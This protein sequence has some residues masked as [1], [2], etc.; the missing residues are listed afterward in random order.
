MNEDFYE[1]AIIEYLVENHDYTHLYGPDVHR[2]TANYQD[3]YLTEILWD[4]LSRINPKLPYAAIEQAVIK[5][6]T[7]ETGRLE[8]RNEVFSDYLQSG[9]EVHF[10][11][12]HE[13]RDDIVYLLDYH[14]PYNNSFHVVNQWTFIEHSNKR[15]DLVLF[16]AA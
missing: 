16:A 11:D 8:Y 9:V 12:G 14:D 2:Q 4:S 5:L 15:P 7:V 1:Q 10:F 13:E 6:E 3:V